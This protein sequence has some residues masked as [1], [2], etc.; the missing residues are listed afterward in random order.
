MPSVTLSGF[1]PSVTIQVASGDLIQFRGDSKVYQVVRDANSD[2]SGNVIVELS[3]IMVREPNVSFSIR[4]G[5]DVKFQ[6]FLER[7]P[8]AVS[9]PGRNG[10]PLYSFSEAV[11][12][13]EGLRPYDLQPGEDILFFEDWSNA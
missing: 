3:S 10:E 12:L 6:L 11:L 13:T 9:I 8:V 4:W 7:Q 2:G 1:T 5:E